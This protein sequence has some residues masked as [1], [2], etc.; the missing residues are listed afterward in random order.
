MS[1]FA[2][3]FGKFFGRRPSDYREA[4]PKEEPAP[5]WP[6]SLTDFLDTLNGNPPKDHIRRA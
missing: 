4:W 5:S 2:F 3:S 1:H 6:G